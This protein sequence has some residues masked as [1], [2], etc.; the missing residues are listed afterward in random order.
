MPTQSLILRKLTPAVPFAVICR[1]SPEKVRE[2][3]SRWR[4]TPQ[5]HRQISGLISGN[6]QPH[7]EISYPYVLSET[8]HVVLDKTSTSLYHLWF[9][10]ELAHDL[11]LIKIQKAVRGTDGKIMADLINLEDGYIVL[12]IN[13]SKPGAH[14]SFLWD[15]VAEVTDTIYAATAGS[16]HEYFLGEM[17]QQVSPEPILEKRA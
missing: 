13:L 10:K 12:K 11:I 17:F 4:L 1:L 2:S 3:F 15:A 7:L 6:I 14:E 5:M 16:S 8:P 9:P